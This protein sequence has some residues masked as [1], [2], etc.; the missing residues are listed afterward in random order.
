MFLYYNYYKFHKNVLARTQFLLA[1]DYRT[2][3]NIEPSVEMKIAPI[4]TRDNKIGS[5]KADWNI[6]FTQIISIPDQYKKL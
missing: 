1:L 4:N 5:F 2:V 3:L 6:T